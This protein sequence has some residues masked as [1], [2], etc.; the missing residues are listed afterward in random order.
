MGDNFYYYDILFAFLQTKAPSE[1]ESTLTLLLL[2]MTCPVL[3]NSVA[4]D[5]GFWRSQLI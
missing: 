4:P 2:Y 5:Q 1:R 3:A